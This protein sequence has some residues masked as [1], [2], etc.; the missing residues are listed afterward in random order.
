MRND[1]L[2]PCDKQKHAFEN[3]C[4]E[5]NNNLIFQFILHYH[6]QGYINLYSLRQYLNINHKYE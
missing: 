6:T 5:N 3:S 4:K 1:N 2:R